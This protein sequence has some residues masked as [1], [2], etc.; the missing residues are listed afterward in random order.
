MDCR[1][2]EEGQ[3]VL[4]C[5]RCKLFRYDGGASQWRERGVGDI[6]ILRDS[7]SNKNRILMRREHVLKLCANHMISTGMVLMIF[8][9]SDKA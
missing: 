1:T 8:P 5:E 6:K 7:N 9:N 2:G 4:F 3:E